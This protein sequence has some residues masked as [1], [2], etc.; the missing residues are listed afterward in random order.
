M[1]NAAPHTVHSILYS[2]PGFRGAGTMG[3]VGELSPQNKYCGGGTPVAYL[4]LHLAH[5][6]NY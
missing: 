1:L 6:T 5:N 3:A 2:C 4:Y